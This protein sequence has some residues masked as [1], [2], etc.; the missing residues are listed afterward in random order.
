MENIITQVNAPV[1][2]NQTGIANLSRMI[3][4]EVK[5]NP[6]T[7]KSE[8]FSRSVFERV[9]N[10]LSSDVAHQDTKYKTMFIY[11]LWK[12]F[13][14]YYD[15]TLSSLSVDELKNVLQ[16]EITFNEPTFKGVTIYNENVNK[17]LL[18]MF[19][20]NI[21]ELTETEKILVDSLGMTISEDGNISFVTVPTTGK[22]TTNQHDRTLYFVGGAGLIVLSLFFIQ[23][24]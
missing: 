11:N 9:L 8:L 24:L 7:S 23:R 12:E 3:F 22:V 16:D 17:I 5:D 19:K 21:N 13:G 6:S 14:A 20:N 10:S 18:Y 15:T 2:F 4:D 1:G